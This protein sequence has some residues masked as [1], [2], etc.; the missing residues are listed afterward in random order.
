M[1]CAPKPDSRRSWNKDSRV[2]TGLRY[3]NSGRSTGPHL[4]YEIRVGTPNP[5]RMAQELDKMFLH[6]TNEPGTP[7]PLLPHRWQKPS[8]AG[9]LFP[10]SDFK[11]SAPKSKA[12]LR[13]SCSRTCTSQAT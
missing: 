6:K 8:L 13:R 10:A 9:P 5:R 4:H 1:I 2:V 11:S 7:L 3:R 12:T